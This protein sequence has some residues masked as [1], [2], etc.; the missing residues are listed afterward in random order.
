MPRS[1][2]APPLGCQMMKPD[3]PSLSQWPSPSAMVSSIILGFG[4]VT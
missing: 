1:W 4:L 3:D 2:V